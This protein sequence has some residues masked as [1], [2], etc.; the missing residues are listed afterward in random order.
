MN[1]VLPALLIL[2]LL[3][4]TTACNKFLKGSITGSVK[5]QSGGSEY[6][7]SFFVVRVLSEDGVV[8]A[9]TG[10][11]NSGYFRFRMN[12]PQTGEDTAL[13]VPW[14]TYILRVFRP[15]LGGGSDEQMVHEEEIVL[16]KG[17]GSYALKISSDN[18]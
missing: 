11:D 6:A 4:T 10:T 7:A 5:I 18:L 9:T 13:K 17:V 3:A 16:R 1:R 12:D 15:N 14:G 2:S 8:I